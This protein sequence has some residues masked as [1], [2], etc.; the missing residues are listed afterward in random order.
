MLLNFAL[1]FLIFGVG[2]KKLNPYLGA[3]LYGGIKGG[4]AVFVTASLAAGA[5]KFALY[6]AL[7]AGLLFLLARIDR[8]E[9]G[10]N[11]ISDYALRRKTSFKWEYVPLSAI[12]V[13]LLFGE[14]LATLFIA[15]AA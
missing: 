13:L 15:P 9:A 4:L 5:I 3:A 11:T 2:K 7:A 8:K 12:V 6:A 1:V 14:L 10:E